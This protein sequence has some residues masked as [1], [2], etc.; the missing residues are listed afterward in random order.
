MKNNLKNAVLFAGVFLV[1]SQLLTACHTVSGT[2]NGAE[3]DVRAAERAVTPDYSA[4][5]HH[6]YAKK[7]AVHH[8]VKHHKKH[9]DS[10]VEN[11]EQ[12]TNTNTN[13]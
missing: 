3:R 9:V 10:S 11:Q 5:R 13:S 8:R 6:H 7:Q 1:G 4:K 2:V 12:N